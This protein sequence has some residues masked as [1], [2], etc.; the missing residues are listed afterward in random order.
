[1]NGQQVSH[2]LIFQDQ[3]LLEIGHAL[4]PGEYRILLDYAWRSQHN[5]LIELHL[6]IPN[7]KTSKRVRVK[8]KSPGGGISIGQ[9]GFYRAL[10]IR[11][12]VGLSRT[13]EM[14]TCTIT[15]LEEGTQIEKW[16]LTD[17][18]HLLPYQVLDNRLSFPVDKVF[19]RYPISRT[20]KLAFA[21]DAQPFEEKVILLL[22]G[23]PGEEIKT[24]L[25]LEGKGL[26][27]TIQN[28]RF[29]LE[30]HPQSGQINKINYIQEEVNLYNE[31]GPIHWNPGCFIPGLGWDHSFNRNPPGD[32]KEINGKLLYVNSRKGPFPHIKDIDLEVKYTVE[33]SAPYFIVDTRMYVHHDL[34]AIALRNDE[35]VLYKDLF[36]HYMYKDHSGEIIEKPLKALEDRPYGLVDIVSEDLEWVGL[37]N[38]EKNYGFFCVR[39]DYVNISLNSGGNLN[40]KSGTY[41]YAPSDG[42]YVYWVRPLVYTWAEYTTN[43]LHSAI[44]GGS[45]YY[46]RNAYILL[47]MDKDVP[48]VLDKL[49]KRLKHPLWVY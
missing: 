29:S 38:R 9:E 8:G 43:N 47:P 24:K 17:G 3:K 11:E 31:V 26:G 44:P 4:D 34:G 49:R 41:F 42:K 23:D 13:E 28:D 35:M 40:H 22:N 39:L 36:D 2:P 46:E 32:F 5:Y 10:V 1:V 14:V 20:L 37:V 18:S 48:Q 19:H 6:R 16:I 7:R 25:Q 27:K 30:F 21:V 12:P 45:S 15:V 33:K